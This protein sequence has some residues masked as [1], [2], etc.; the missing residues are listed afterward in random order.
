MQSGGHTV[1]GAQLTVFPSVDGLS[2]YQ[3]VRVNVL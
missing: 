2:V 3:I 1:V